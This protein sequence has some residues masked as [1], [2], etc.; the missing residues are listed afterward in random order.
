MNTSSE[1]VFHDMNDWS[2]SGADGSVAS[3]CKD[4]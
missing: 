2:N 3:K 4:G 1:E